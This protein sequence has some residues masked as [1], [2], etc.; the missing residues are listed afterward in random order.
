MS[1]WDSNVDYRLVQGENKA[2]G[3]YFIGMDDEKDGKPASEDAF[4]KLTKGSCL[5]MI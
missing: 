2:C 5:S 4:T 3:V 1:M